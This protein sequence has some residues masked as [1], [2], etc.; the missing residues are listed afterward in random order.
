MS[1]IPKIKMEK[2][3]I[4]FK[5]RGE[6]QAGAAAGGTLLGKLGEKIAQKRLGRNDVEAI[7]RCA[8]RW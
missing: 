8:S 7:T 6:T 5:F 3:D 2:D 4:L 1:G